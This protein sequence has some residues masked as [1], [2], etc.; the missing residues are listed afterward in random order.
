MIEFKASVAKAE[1]GVGYGSDE[2]A[3]R[4]HV[5]VANDGTVEI[6]VDRADDEDSPSVVAFT[7]DNEQRRRLAAV[8]TGSYPRR[9]PS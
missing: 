7:L 9:D 3:V 8:L 5:L 1:V 6:F 2:V 4:L